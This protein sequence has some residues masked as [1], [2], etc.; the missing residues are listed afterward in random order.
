MRKI[1][2]LGDSFTWG[3]GLELYMDKEPFKSMRTQKATDLELEQISNYKDDEVESWR[4]GF[5]FAG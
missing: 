2:F 5:R 3:E 4:R 1:L